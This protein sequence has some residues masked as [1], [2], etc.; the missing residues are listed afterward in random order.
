MTEGLF[1]WLA[2][3]LYIAIGIVVAFLARRRL[4]SARVPRRKAKQFLQYLYEALPK[5]NFVRVA[6]NDT[7][8]CDFFSSEPIFRWTA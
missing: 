3:V 2:I 8:Y 5:G 6:Q 1:V 7:I 4:G